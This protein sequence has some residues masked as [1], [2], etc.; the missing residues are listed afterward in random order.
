MGEAEPAK[1]NLL[2]MFLTKERWK[3][4]EPM[5]RKSKDSQLG[6]ARQAA[7]VSGDDRIRAL[8]QR[9]VQQVF[10]AEM[11]TS[12]LGRRELRAHE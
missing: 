3:G 1:Q 8:V 11:T 2:K 10:E 6:E 9:V 7:A 5:A 4:E 12:F